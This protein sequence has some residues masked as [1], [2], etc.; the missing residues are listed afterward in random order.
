MVWLFTNKSTLWQSTVSIKLNQT[1][2]NI[3]FTLSAIDILFMP[4]RKVKIS[5]KEYQHNANMLD[6]VEQT[7]QYVLN[8]AYDK[9]AHGSRR[10]ERNDYKTERKSGIR[11]V[12]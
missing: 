7:T 4:L 3:I 2:C 6:Q 12:C 11:K 9:L 5:L 8:E 10:T 1:S